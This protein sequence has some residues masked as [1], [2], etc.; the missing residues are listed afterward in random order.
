MLRCRILIVPAVACCGL[1]GMS[2]LAAPILY[3][4]RDE[5]EAFWCFAGLMDRMEVICP[6]SFS[7]YACYAHAARHAY[8]L[9]IWAPQRDESQGQRRSFAP[10]R[11]EDEL[12]DVQ[13]RLWTAGP[14][15][16]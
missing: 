7:F 11:A 10:S 3:V 15:D 9:R 8:G 4:M 12:E 14:C 2:D 5:V 6:S 13:H 16:T 1:Q